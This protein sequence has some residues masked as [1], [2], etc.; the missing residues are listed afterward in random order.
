MITANTVTGLAVHPDGS[1]SLSIVG[2]GPE[3]PVS[4]I[5]RLPA[6]LDRTQAQLESIMP[7]RLEALVLDSSGFRHALGRDGRVWTDRMGGWAA[8]QLGETQLNAMRPQ[9]DVLFLAG[10]AGF[11][12]RLD[13]TTQQSNGWNDAIK[14]DLY[15][16]SGTSE[17]LWAVGNGGTVLRWDGNR[18][19]QAQG[20]PKADL[21]SVMVLRSAVW[22]AGEQG[23]FASF[24]E[25]RW[26]DYSVASGPSFTAIGAVGG[27]AFLAGGTDGLFAVTDDGPAW[28]DGGDFSRMSQ[29]RGLLYLFGGGK[30]GIHDG[31]MLKTTEMEV[32]VETP[33]P[34]AAAPSEGDEA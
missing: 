26:L 2:Q 25:G 33:E 32:Q 6:D 16:L 31:N 9:G 27:K 28:T 8:L 23:T 3:G 18:W 14:Q 1:L 29:G 21:R 30:V 22:V 24:T 12:G 34:A 15:A 20:G 19:G 17:N 13:W 7:D 4:L 11:R 10:A 5:M